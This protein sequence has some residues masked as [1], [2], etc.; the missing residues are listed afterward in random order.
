MSPHPS[1][2][3]HIASSPASALP[4]TSGWSSTGSTAMAVGCTLLVLRRGSGGCASAV[5][6]LSPRQ[7]PPSLLVS[8]PPLTTFSFLKRAP[9]VEADAP[10]G[11]ASP[12]VS[13]DGPSSRPMEAGVG[14][15]LS[16]LRSRVTASLSR[17]AWALRLTS[18]SFSIAETA[19]APSDCAWRLTANCCPPSV[20]LRTS[21]LRRAAVRCNFSLRF[22]IDFMNGMQSNSAER[23]LT[24]TTMTNG[25]SRARMM[26]APTRKG[27]R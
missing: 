3:A 21:A 10:F 11:A 1:T 15:T 22:R 5:P 18:R 26:S 16:L 25:K 6:L 7:M 12:G 8:A 9:K 4:N 19:L 27:A 23:S 13:P 2:C 20:I 24:N 17:S 14:S